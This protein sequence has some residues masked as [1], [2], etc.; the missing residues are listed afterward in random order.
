[1]KTLSHVA[2]YASKLRYIY[3]CVYNIPVDK[4]V[5]FNGRYE[6]SKPPE[7]PQPS[8]PPEPSEPSE[9][10]NLKEH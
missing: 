6:P 9:L 10:L 2:K 3:V 1:M 5:L 4:A 7:P 8:E